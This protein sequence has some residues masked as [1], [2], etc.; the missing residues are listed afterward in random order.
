MKYGLPEVENHQGLSE[1]T[2]PDPEQ[3]TIQEEE[4]VPFAG[5]ASNEHEGSQ[6]EQ[7]FSPLSPDGLRHVSSPQD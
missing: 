5:A 6:G 2:V 1:D 7:T 3:S 4:T